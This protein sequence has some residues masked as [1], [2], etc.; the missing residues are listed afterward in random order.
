MSSTPAT[1][2]AS[3]CSS[4]VAGTSACSASPICS[5]V[6]RAELLDQLLRHGHEVRFAAATTLMR[7]GE[8]SDTLMLVTSG[9]VRVERP[10]RTLTLGIGALIG[11]IEVLDPGAGRMATITAETDTTCVVVTRAELL[12]GLAEDP[13]AAIALLG[14]LASRFR[15][16]G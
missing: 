8:A 3:R 16:A 9:S 14:I 5:R 2:K 7:Q 11:E 6:S 15:E 12:E 4:T 13:Q 10:G 1:A